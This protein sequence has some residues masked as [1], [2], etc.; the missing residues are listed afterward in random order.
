MPGPDLGP[1]H[2]LAGG[3]G[4]LVVAEEWGRRQT[5]VVIISYTA[6]AS[7]RRHKCP[8]EAPSQPRMA[9]QRVSRS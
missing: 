3:M 8:E 9:L 1:G 4:V 2:R 7:P 5:Q 6:K